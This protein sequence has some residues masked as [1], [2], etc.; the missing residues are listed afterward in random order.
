MRL[1]LCLSIW[2]AMGL[3]RLPHGIGRIDV[4]QAETRSVRDSVPAR[5]VGRR[6]NDH[7][8]RILLRARLRVSMTLG[9]DDPRRID[10]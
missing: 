8:N 10:E 7:R 5:E 3:S 6:R 4:L 2:S 9:Q 1:Q